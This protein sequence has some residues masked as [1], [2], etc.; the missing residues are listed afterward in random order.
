MR[1]QNLAM[2]MMI[3][4]VC[5][6]CRSTLVHRNEQC[7]PVFV[8]TDET[9]KFISVNESFCNVRGYEYSLNHLGPIPGTERKEPLPYC[10]RCVGVKDYAGFV[11]FAEL[12]RREI[13]DEQGEEFGEVEGREPREID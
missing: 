12:V 4:G 8:Y 5:L 7:S 2:L 6:S 9:R 1:I 11:T 13:L 10:D 3:F